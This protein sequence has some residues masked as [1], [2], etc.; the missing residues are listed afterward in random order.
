MSQILQLVRSHNLQP[1]DVIVVGRNGG[2]AAHYLVVMHRDH[3]GQWFMANLE[4]GVSWLD[5]DYL[6]SRSHE[7]FFK[8]IRRFEGDWQQRQA[9]L[10]RAES[11]HGEGYDLVR[12]NCEHF[13]NYVQFGKESSA[14]VQ[15]VGAGLG[16]AAGIGLAWLLGRIFG[17]DEQDDR[18]R[19]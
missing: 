3:R 2:L 11:R 15:N 16:V 1:G 7:F 5:E 14:Q 8:R 4:Q 9:A 17:G 18:L 13:A 19:S 10:R 6:H 12:F